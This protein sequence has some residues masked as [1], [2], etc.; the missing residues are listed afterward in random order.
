[1]QREY[2][3]EV[4]I[5]STNNRNTVIPVSMLNSFLKTAQL[6]KKPLFRSYYNFPLAFRTH[7]MQNKTVSGYHG[8]VYINNILLDIDRGEA[9][10][11]ETLDRA[12]EF[13][14]RLGDDYNIPQEDI[15][16]FFSGRG[17]HIVMPDHFGFEP[18]PK[19]P[20]LVS[21]TLTTVFPEADNIFDKTRIIR[22]ANTLNEKTNLYKV[23]LTREEFFS[24]SYESITEL[25]KTPRDIKIE[26]FSNVQPVLS[27]LLVKTEKSKDKQGVKIVVGNDY[28]RIATCAHKMWNSLADVE[29]NR[30]KKMMRISSSWRRN[31][32]PPDA[33]QLA[34]QSRLPTMPKED[35]QH[36]VEGKQYEFSCNDE[37]MKAYCDPRCVF[38]HKKNY[39]NA[40]KGIDQLEKEFGKFL[41]TDFTESSFN[42]A[43]LYEMKEPFW[44]YPGEFVS[45]IGDTGRGKT[46]IVQNWMVHFKHL[47][48]LAL[49]LEVGQNLFFRRLIQIA[50]GMTKQEVI[51]YYQHNTNHLS[52]AVKHIRVSMQAP[53]LE[54]LKAM[55]LDNQ[56]NVLVIDTIED[57]EIQDA[58]DATAI[59]DGAAR[60]LQ[61]LAEEMKIIVIVVHHISKSA[62]LDQ[63]GKRK[64]LTQH[65][66]K[67][68]SAVEQ[69]ADKLIAVEGEADSP[70]RML[71][72]KK[73]RDEAPFA[74]SLL[75]Q[76]E[77]FT[78]KQLGGRQWKPEQM[79]IP[80]SET[81]SSP[82]LQ[83]SQ[84][85]SPEPTAAEKSQTSGLNSEHFLE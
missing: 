23:F 62:A 60:A 85:P 71:S 30:H 27:D 54:G 41:S 56:P 32:M 43:D 52:D 51:R 55:I 11:A 36:I 37:L 69:K 2:Y 64:S 53:T 10:D 75:M 8:M 48:W 22:M 14:T 9:T 63:D 76:H 5:G 24:G 6:S 39:G 82:T 81:P 17:Y 78:F 57:L 80:T 79:E 84:N 46:A 74:I 16:I 73:A 18:S 13:V 59:T 66:G 20:Q 12:R 42:L 49:S 3:T 34:F 61:K 58:K 29:G 26:P 65:S 28:T 83:L 38:Y 72:S 67:G 70:H 25:S 19:L 4:V 68:S 50:H 47:K 44:F 35:I 40:T 77:T 45:V 7:A 15:R 1:M 31:S 33:I 21:E